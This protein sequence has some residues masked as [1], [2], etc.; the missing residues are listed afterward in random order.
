[1]YKTEGDGVTARLRFSQELQQQAKGFVVNSKEG[2]L[3][4]EIM[5]DMTKKNYLKQRVVI[6][7]IIPTVQ[8]ICESDI[9]PGDIPNVVQT[10]RDLSRVHFPVPLNGQQSP[11]QISQ[12]DTPNVSTS[13]YNTAH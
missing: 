4:S 3:N 12:D 5:K 1:M 11:K 9:A 10:E 13:I 8:N 7:E 6:D 2:S